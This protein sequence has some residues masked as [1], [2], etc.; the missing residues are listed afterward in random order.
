MHINATIYLFVVDHPLLVCPRCLRLKSPRGSERTV[1]AFDDLS[2]ID[3]KA[4]SLTQNCPRIS[5][6]SRANIDLTCKRL[7]ELT[8]STAQYSVCGTTVNDT[9][10][11]SNAV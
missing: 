6:V 9:A 8:Y 2:G 4:C 1:A 10:V 7:L 5:P 3:I 11:L